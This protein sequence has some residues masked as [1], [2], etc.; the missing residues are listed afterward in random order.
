MFLLDLL[1]AFFLALVLASLIAGPAGWRH[2]RLASGRAAAI[3]LFLVLLPLIWA[4]G[5]WL[6]PMGPEVNGSYWLPT[7]LVGLLLGLLVLSIGSAAG[8]PTLRGDIPP[9]AEPDPSEAAALGITAI[10][11]AFFWL[12]LLA[13]I[14]SVVA[15]Y[16]V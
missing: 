11:G 15:F 2:P 7:L 4:G 3:F 14:A 6:S 5:L 9:A 8:D 13:G 1:F 16:A 12:L 10:F